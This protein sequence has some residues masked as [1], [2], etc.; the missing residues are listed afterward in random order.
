M[1]SGPLAGVRVVEFAGIGP[2]PFA[3]MMLADMGAEMVTLVRPGAPPFSPS[4]FAFRGRH[5][6]Q[7]NLKDPSDRE[8]AL[9]LLDKADIAVEGFRPGVMERLGLGPDVVH[10]RNPGLIYGRM[11]GWGQTGPLAAAAAHDIN[12]IAITGALHAIGTRNDPVPPLNLL[13][14]YGGG[15]LYLVVGLLAALNERRNSGLGQVIDAAICDGVLSLM[16]PQAGR[17]LSGRDVQ[18]RESNLLD[19]GSACYGVYRT[20]DDEHV[21]IGAIE[22]EF[23]ARLCA[24][25]GIDPALRDDKDPARDRRF[26]QALEE[27]FATRTRAQWCELLEGT[28]AC[29]APVLRLSEARTHPHLVARSAFAD[30]GGVVQPAAAPRFSRTPSRVRPVEP[31]ETFGWEDALARWP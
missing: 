8:H 12:Y 21:S 22:P 15:S 19:G 27:T 14:D 16:T 20:S 25:L 17:Y 30:V 3:C 18:A 9:E 2:A 10:A 6:V 26:R 23:H 13:G 28:D 1:S 7:V 4:Q 31:Q 29:F 11:T 24:L 5:R